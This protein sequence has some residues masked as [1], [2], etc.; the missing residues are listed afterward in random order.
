MLNLGVG[1][2]NIVHVCIEPCTAPHQ[3]FYCL[4]D[5]VDCPDTKLRFLIASTISLRSIKFCTFD[6]GIITP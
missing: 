6:L 4:S 1:L 3:Y 5:I 2:D